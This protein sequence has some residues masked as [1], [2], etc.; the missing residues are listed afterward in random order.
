MNICK[1]FWNGLPFVILIVLLCLLGYWEATLFAVI[2]VLVL[3]GLVYF[4]DRMAKRCDK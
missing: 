3:F 1:L 2:V 4:C